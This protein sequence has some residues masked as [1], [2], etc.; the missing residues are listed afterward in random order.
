MSVPQLSLC[1][2]HSEMNTADRKYPCGPERFLIMRLKTNPRHTGGASFTD[3]PAVEASHPSA[4]LSLPF[5]PSGAG[6]QVGSS[7]A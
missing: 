6:A 5:I 2:L 7:L 4:A 3:I 1:K